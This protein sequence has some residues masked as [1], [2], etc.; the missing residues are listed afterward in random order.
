MS[1]LR[2]ILVA[3]IAL[4]VALLPVAG[5]KALNLS[6]ET[7]LVSV[8]SDCCAQGEHCD[9]QQKGDC[10]KLAGCGLKCSGFSAAFAG[11]SGIVLAPSRSQKTALATGAIGSPT[12]NPPSPPPRV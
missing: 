4:S 6:S 2:A 8:Q 9:K 1:P 12:Y 11:P 3:F 7:S 5:A 10:T